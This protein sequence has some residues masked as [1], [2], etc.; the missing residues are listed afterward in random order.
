MKK[1]WTKIANIK[2]HFTKQTALYF[3]YMVF[4]CS[5]I[6]ANTISAKLMT[7]PFELFGQP[8]QLTVGAIVYP[9]T[10]I[11]TDIIGE[12]YGHKES[13]IAIVGGFICQVICTLLIMLAQ[14]IPTSD[15]NMQEHYVA[16]LGQNWI[17]VLAS[18]TAYLISQ[19]TD[20]FVFHK[21]KNIF[22]RK[23]NF[24][25]KW[26][27]SGASTVIGQFLDSTIYALIAFGLGFGFLWN[28]PLALV[29]MIL[30]QWIIKTLISLV[31]IPIF[32]LFT[33]ERRK[34]IE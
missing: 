2:N 17:F 10:F 23:N 7:L 26:L 6:I 28:N 13:K 8:V 34:K 14:I 12:K 4:A 33:I 15:N 11:V 21:I 16:L 20:R 25:M 29:G 31:S 5:L 18:L 3:L 19:F 9:I 32:Y 22:I 1:I 27:Y 30:A 24:K